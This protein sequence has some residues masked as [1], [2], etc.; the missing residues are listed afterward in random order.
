M[1]MHKLKRNESKKLVQI[2]QNLIEVL[3]AEAKNFPL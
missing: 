1:I 3:H 2:K